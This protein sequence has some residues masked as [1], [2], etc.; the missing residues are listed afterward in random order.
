M[1]VEIERKFLVSS[2][3]FKAKAFKKIYI[4]QGFLNSDK[5]RVVRVRLKE[6]QGFL[7]IKGSSNEKGTTRFEWEKKINKSDVE[8]LFEL[9]EKDVI[10]K[11]RYLVKIEN[12]TYEIDE[13]L[14][15]NKGLIIAE[16]ELA[17]EEE[18][19]RKPSWLAEEVTGEDRYYNSNLSKLPYKNW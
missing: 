4:K 7:T 2:N 16:I 5:E 19:F 8:S 13:F 9:C 6:N 15:A 18:S 11:F 3:D 14:G 10:E 17:S 1:S 12:H